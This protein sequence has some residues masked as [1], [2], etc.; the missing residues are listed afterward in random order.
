MPFRFRGNIMSLTIKVVIFLSSV[1]AQAAGPQSEEPKEM[2]QRIRTKTA[3]QLSHLLNYTCHQVVDRWART[4]SSRYLNY[5][6]QVE[7]EVAF[8]GNKELFGR[9]REARIEEESVTSIV[10]TGPI[11]NGGVS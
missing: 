4:A 8:I 2:L 5:R 6:D 9:P 10:R 1:G 7:F 11:G 3:A